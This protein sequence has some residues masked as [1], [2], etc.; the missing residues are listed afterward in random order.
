M[1]KDNLSRCYRF[2]LG[3]GYIIVIY[4]PCNKLITP[5]F[6]IVRY[7]FIHCLTVNNFSSGQSFYRTS[8]SAPAVIGIPF[9][10][11]PSIITLMVEALSALK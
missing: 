7:C 4:K 3:M 5:I 8:Y 1:A 10:V 9:I 6:L 11:I 2:V